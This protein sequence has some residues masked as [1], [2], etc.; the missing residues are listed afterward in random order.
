[1]SKKIVRLTP[2]L[3][4]KLVLE[5]KQKI[6]KELEASSEAKEQAWAGGDNLVHK[7]DYVKKL[8]IKE[9]KLAKLLKTVRK[10]R[11]VAKSSII[12]DLKR[13]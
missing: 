13:R 8:G 10:A 5:E 1:M 6:N 11:N 7:I 9:A 2:A 4:K 12:K 3:L